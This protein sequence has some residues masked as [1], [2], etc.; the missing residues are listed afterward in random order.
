LIA[1]NA[2]YPSVGGL[3]P[4]DVNGTPSAV[5]GLAAAVSPSFVHLSWAAPAS[6]SDFAGVEIRYALGSTP[7]AT[8]TDGLDGGR[9]L[10]TSRDLG[11]LPPDQDVAI[12]VFSRDWTGHV[13]P[14]ATTVTTTP[15]LT[16]STL[17][18]HAA[19]PDIVYG[20]SS[21]I[22]A[23]LTRTYDGTPLADAAVTIAT[24]HTNTTDPFI[25]RTT[26]PTD[27][28]GKLSY[29]QI[30]GIGYDYQLRYTGDTDNAAVTAATRIRVAHRVTETLDHASAPGR[31]LRPPHR[32][33]RPQ[34]PQ[35]QDLP[36]E[37]HHPRHHPRPA[38][39]QQRQQ[40][41]LHHHRTRQRHHD[42]IPR[43]RPQQRQLHHRLRN[44]AHHHRHVSNTG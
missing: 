35:R 8:V 17:T 44:L 18:A 5:S 12:S 27:A 40:S 3:T 4:A 34:L 21:T 16:A 25:D 14:A 26:I 33:H 13:G 38:Q 19:P 36:T 39:H 32:H 31:Q 11:P 7:P 29:L 15:H 23:T 37:V 24:R 28:T 43:R 2:L 22:T 30:P 6:T 42:Q 10:A 9:L 20:H 41:H 1:D